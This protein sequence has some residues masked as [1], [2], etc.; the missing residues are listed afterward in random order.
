MTSSSAIVYRSPYILLK[1]YMTILKNTLIWTN[2]MFNLCKVMMRMERHN[3][4]QVAM[5]VLLGKMWME[6]HNLIQIA[7]TVLLGL[8]LPHLVNLNTRNKPLRILLS[9]MVWIMLRKQVT[10]GIVCRCLIRLHPFPSPLSEV[11]VILTVIKFL[12]IRISSEHFNG[13]KQ[14]TL[15][16]TKIESPQGIRRT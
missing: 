6:W 14:N 2:V 10:I 16:G 15:C 8:P 3:L 9:I 13:G 1:P 5:I 4:I 11:Y 12:L 7:M